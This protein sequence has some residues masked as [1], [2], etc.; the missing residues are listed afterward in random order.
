MN[1]TILKN[2]AIE[3]NGTDRKYMNVEP[4]IILALLEDLEQVTTDRDDYK[5]A[6][7]NCAEIAAVEGKN[8]RMMVE[9]RDQWKRCHEKLKEALEKEVLLY[10]SYGEEDTH[11]HRALSADSNHE[12]GESGK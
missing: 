8:F 10:S 3:I 1:K 4:Y 7:F 12:K 5:R 2:K 6:A 9:D 11:A